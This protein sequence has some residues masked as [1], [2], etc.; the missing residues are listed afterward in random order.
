[1]NEDNVSTQF[2][3]SGLFCTIA[4]EIY[5]QTNWML[6]DKLSEILDLMDDHNQKRI[7]TIDNIFTVIFFFK[8][9]TF[10]AY[11]LFVYYCLLFIY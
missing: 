3:L 6:S 10:T 4:E 8:L 11:T 2:N 1:M 9:S 7:I 5:D